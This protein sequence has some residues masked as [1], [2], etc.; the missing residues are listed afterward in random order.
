MQLP[1]MATLLRGP[2]K[3]IGQPLSRKDGPAKVTGAAKYAG[4]FETQGLLF[5]VI[6]SSAVARG[7]IQRIDAAEALAIPGVVYVFTHENRPNLAWFD[8]KWKDKDSPKG[9]PF[10][11]LYDAEIVHAMQP[12]ALVVAESFEAARA[13]ARLVEVDYDEAPHQT[14]LHAAREKA[15]VP[16]PK[17]KGGFE[18]PPKPR[19]DADRAFAEAEAQIDAEYTLPA[20]H[21]NPMELFATTVFCNDDG[22]LTIHD[23]TQGV[24]GVQSYVC[25]VFDLPPA[26]VR[27]LSPFVGGAFGSGLRAQQQLFMA[28]MAATQLKRSVRVELTRP[29]MFTIGRRPESIQ[30]V[31]LG[32]KRDGTLKALI[33][34][35]VQETSQNENFVEIVVNWSGQQYQCDNVRLEYKLARLDAHTPL[36]MRAPGAA[37]GMLAIETAIDE[38]ACELGIDPVELRLTNYTERDPN[39]GRPFSSKELKACFAQGAQRFGW[40]RRQNTPRTVKEGNELVGYGMACGLWDALQGQASATA[41]LSA[42]GKLTVAS[43]TADIGTG[44]Y[45]V[46]AQIAAESLG[47]P[48]EDVSFKLGDSSL[49]TSPLEGGSWT[50]ATVGSAVKLVCDEVADQLLELARKLPMSPFKAAARDEV[51]FDEGFISL[52]GDP[53]RRIAIDELLRKSN[54]PAIEHTAKSIPFVMQRMKYT[55]ATHSAVFVEVRV[56]EDLG[57]ARIG[58]VVSAVAAGRIVNPKTARS[59]VL[60]AVVGGV[61]MALHEE[62]MVDHALG[63]YMNHDLAEYHVPVNAD[64]GDIEVIFVEEHDEAVNALGAK[65]VGEI[66]IVGVAAAVGN[67]IYNATGKRVREFPITLDKLLR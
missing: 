59:Q 26:G 29:Q 3:K 48:V 6:V 66:G 65:G 31:R 7:R 63:R 41:V 56:D 1:K 11:P 18:P 38:L 28:V 62:T 44:T 35:A 27:V 37:T 4:E 51:V 2:T 15:F 19:G 10:R 36:D 9:A 24:Q 21:H 25:N 42:D 8:R 45:T 49:P 47:L 40:Q 52:K 13:G 39:Q 22:T 67:A 54:V 20:E 55:F 34:E 23:K 46:M 64:V 17:D 58:R 30:R 14:D 5:G 57:M 43:A 16:G 33:H 53:D 61:G 12:V 50:V 32:A 60:G